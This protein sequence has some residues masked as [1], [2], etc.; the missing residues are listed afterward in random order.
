MNASQNPY[1]APQSESA[2]FA[3]R[4]YLRSPLPCVARS[5]LVKAKLLYRRIVIEAPIE[6]VLE[7]RAY[8]LGDRIIVDGQTMARKVAWLWFADRFEFLLPSADSPIRVAVDVRVRP[9]LAVGWLRI[10][11]DDVIV[12]EEGRPPKASN[13]SAARPIPPQK[14]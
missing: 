13:G 12:Y 10:A 3:F 8:E 1:A 9:W 11:I 2:S 14:P 4:R 5:Q 7:W 6:A